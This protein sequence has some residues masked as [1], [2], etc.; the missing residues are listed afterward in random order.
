[1]AGLRLGY[2]V[3]PADAMVR[4]RRVANHTVYNISCALQAAGLAALRE[5]DDFLLESRRLYQ[6]A[7]D[8]L[9][10]ALHG[11]SPVPHGG[12]YCF[13]ELESEETAWKFLHRALDLGLATAPGEAFGEHF[14]HCLR[15]CFTAAPLE[16][17]ER[18]ARTLVRV[19]EEMGC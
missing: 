4:L 11:L 13:L 3:A 14:R 2:V 9:A 19:R 12:A 18:A 8:E 1:M 16:G 6:P 17:V 15:I 5:G 10:G 7:R